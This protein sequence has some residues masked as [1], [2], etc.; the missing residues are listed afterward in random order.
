MMFSIPIKKCTP[1]VL[2]PNVDTIKLV[3]AIGMRSFYLTSH[4]ECSMKTVDTVNRLKA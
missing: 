4:I 1:E 3:G 2:G